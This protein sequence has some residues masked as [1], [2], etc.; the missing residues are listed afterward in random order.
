[1]ADIADEAVGPDDVDDDETACGRAFVTPDTGSDLELGHRPCVGF[2]FEDQV[3]DSPLAL[4]PALLGCSTVDEE[5]VDVEDANEEEEFDLWTLL[6]GINIRETSSAFI[7]VSAACPPLLAAYHPKRGP[8]CTL[9][10][11]A[12]AVMRRQDLTGDRSKG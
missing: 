5:E 1:M 3:V 10:G 4:C 12:T 9:G 7:E 2:F 6:R 8:D 11:E